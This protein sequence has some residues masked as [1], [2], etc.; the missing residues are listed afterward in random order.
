MRLTDSIVLLYL[1]LL[2]LPLA[3]LALL[4]RPLGWHNELQTAAGRF[5]VS[6]AGGF[7]TSGFVKTRVQKWRY[8]L[9]LGF[10]LFALFVFS[11]MISRLDSI[12]CAA[13]PVSLPCE[14][15]GFAAALWLVAPTFL[16]IGYGP[17]F[18]PATAASN[19]A[20]GLGTVLSLICLVMAAKYIGE[21]LRLT[22]QEATAVDMLRR[23][24]LKEEAKLAAVRVFVAFWRFRKSLRASVTW[25]RGL[26]MKGHGKDAEKKTLSFLVCC[27][28]AFSKPAS[29]LLALP[30]S[31]SPMARPLALPAPPLPT[32]KTIVPDPAFSPP[33]TVVAP[34]FLSPLPAVLPA[35]LM[36]PPTRRPPLLVSVVD[37]SKA[38][39]SPI[40]SPLPSLG[41]SSASPL[42]PLPSPLHSPARLAAAMVPALKFPPTPGKNTIGPAFVAAGGAGARSFVAAETGAAMILPLPGVA[43]SSAAKPPIS[44]GPV[45]K[46]LSPVNAAAAFLAPPAVG[47]VLSSAPPTAALASTPLPA[48]KPPTASGGLAAFLTLHAGSGAIKQ[49]TN[50]RERMTLLAGKGGPIDPM[51]LIAGSSSGSAS[52]GGGSVNGPRAPRESLST[53]GIRLKSPGK[54]ASTAAPSSGSGQSVG[55]VHP[56]ASPLSPAAGREEGGATFAA[57]TNPLAGIP[58]PM[59]LPTPFFAVPATALAPPVPNDTLSPAV[60]AAD[61][62]YKRKIMQLN[63]EK[64]AAAAEDESSIPLLSVALA[65][66][67][68]SEEDKRA[69]KKRQK[70]LEAMVTAAKEA[71]TRKK[72]EQEKKKQLRSSSATA[73]AAA[74]RTSSQKSG[75]SSGLLGDGTSNK[76]SSTGSSDPASRLP[77]EVSAGGSLVLAGSATTSRGTSAPPSVTALTS[78]TTA[79]TIVTR[80]RGGLKTSSVQ[81]T[82]LQTIA[83]NEILRIYAEPTTVAT[84]PSTPGG[85]SGSGTPVA[86]TSSPLPAAAV[87]M[88]VIVMPKELPKGRK[89]LSSLNPAAKTA[90]DEESALGIPISPRSAASG[91]FA[92]LSDGN[93]RGLAGIKGA[94]KSGEKQSKAGVPAFVLKALENE[95]P[96]GSIKKLLLKLKTMT[97]TSSEKERKAAIIKGLQGGGLRTTS[98]SSVSVAG[99]AAASGPG[100]ARSNVSGAARTVVGGGGSVV[101]GRG[102]GAGPTAKITVVVTSGAGSVVSGHS[103]RSSYKSGHG[104]G[105]PQSVDGKSVDSRKSKVSA[106]SKLSGATGESKAS[107]AAAAAQA[108][109]AMIADD[110]DSKRSRSTSYDEDDPDAW[111]LDFSLLPITFA[112]WMAFLFCSLA[113]TTRLQSVW[114]SFIARLCPSRLRVSARRVSAKG[115]PEAAALEA[116]NRWKIARTT[117]AL[118]SLNTDMLNARSTKTQMVVLE[119]EDLRTQ[120]SLLLQQLMPSAQEREAAVERMEDRRR[121]LKAAAEAGSTQHS[122]TASSSPAHGEL[123]ASPRAGPRRRRSCR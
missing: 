15:L 29:T 7:S 30:P 105:K 96:D 93:K 80:R 60:D 12:Q 82:P 120:V 61:D 13:N 57:A 106:S 101:N 88:L 115:G 42:L 41:P 31:P 46:L 111:R 44:I 25:Q 85:R 5:A 10:L 14:P 52:S 108:A 11:Y 103:G 6:L 19:F 53:K 81:A 54:V 4:L 98:D 39:C 9:F 20:A 51:T 67:A 76:N 92:L 89:E 35:P 112:G 104:G 66:K 16:K 79:T 55:S 34:S 84:L 37:E 99:S 109:L 27:L 40:S 3:R 45:P 94:D 95:A 21:W 1:A 58:S 2:L 114:H 22:P 70:E 78:T 77:T 63:A 121:K 33:P 69:Q 113:C 123:P 102:G 83:S 97:T 38:L 119:V 86:G 17:P 116:M 49:Q 28:P 50:A 56:F 47:N 18:V 72:E 90:A 110:G 122:T 64:A 118:N 32:S 68:R 48:G 75:G 23:A 24:R 36:P 43:L 107:R 73:S 71:K 59:P 87:P 62:A 65:A 74:T 91:V 26:G 100:T 117:L 8:R